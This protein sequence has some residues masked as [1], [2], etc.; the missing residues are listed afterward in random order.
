MDINCSVKRR[1]KTTA[2]TKRVPTRYCINIVHL[3]EE[4]TFL[5]NKLCRDL[6]CSLIIGGLKSLEMKERNHTLSQ[7]WKGLSSSERQD[8]NDRA[9]SECV[10]SKD[11]LINRRFKIF[12]KQV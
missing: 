9:K 3:N 5:L 2:S 11:V 10:V 4:L 8:Y 7:R 1:P 12:K 6:I